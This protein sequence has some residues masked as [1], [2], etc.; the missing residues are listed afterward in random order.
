MAH[1]NIFPT[2]FA[3]TALGY[4]NVLARIFSAV[5]PVLAQMEEPTPMW[6]FTVTA[7]V[8]SVLSLV[9]QE[10]KKNV[11]TQKV[12]DEKDLDRTES[13]LEGDDR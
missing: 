4:C 5:S 3:S 2:L 11:P 8:A 13:S 6:V 12:T 9:L 10:D 7:A 1:C